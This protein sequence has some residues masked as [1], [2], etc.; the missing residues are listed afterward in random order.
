[1]AWTWEEI[2]DDLKSDL[3]DLFWESMESVIELG[4]DILGLIPVP[5]FMENLADVIGDIP[6][7]VM[8]WIEP[9][10]IDYGLSVVMAAVTA[11]MLL[12]L[13]PIVG[14]AFR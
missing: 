3:S 4:A 8:Y 13:I 10:E 6:D 9:F 1:M 2:L 7:S 5:T 12:S 14:G 11:R